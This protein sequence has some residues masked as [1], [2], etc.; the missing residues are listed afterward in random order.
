MQGMIRAFGGFLL[1]LTAGCASHAVPAGS[2]GTPA[3]PKVALLPPPS[4]APMQ[5]VPYARVVSGVDLRGDAW[6][7]WGQAD[8][9]YGRGKKPRA[10]AVLV[11]AKTKRLPRGHV[12]VVTK[13]V[14]PREILVTHANWSSADDERGQVTSNVRIIDISPGNDWSELRVWNDDID[15]FGLVYPA[16][17]FIYPGAAGA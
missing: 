8:G 17:G 11:F 2:A 6:T 14:A 5:C 16:K 15:D 12:S 7:W 10:G 3:E 4:T 1:L 13:I 9:H